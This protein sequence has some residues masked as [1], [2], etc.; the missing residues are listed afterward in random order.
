MSDPIKISSV[1]LVNNKTAQKGK[2]WSDTAKNRFIKQHG[3][4]DDIPEGDAHAVRVY[5]SPAQP[6]QPSPEEQ[7]AAEENLEAQIK[8]LKGEPIQT[9]DKKEQVQSPLPPKPKGN[10]FYDEWVD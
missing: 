7:K 8:A 5:E 6:P 3:S 4:V 10:N 1:L 2:V 9:L